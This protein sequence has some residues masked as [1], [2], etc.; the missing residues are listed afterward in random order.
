MS[1]TIHCE[2]KITEIEG[3]HCAYCRLQHHGS[4]VSNKDARKLKTTVPVRTPK[5]TTY[6][7]AAVGFDLSTIV[8]VPI[9]PTRENIA[10]PADR[11][12]SLSQTKIYSTFSLLSLRESPLY[13][14]NQKATKISVRR[15]SEAEILDNR[16]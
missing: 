10:P 6:S 3:T 13:L 9:F 7:R 11:M 1:T 12:G 8:L 4:I 14:Y 15:D 5:S 16:F 2:C